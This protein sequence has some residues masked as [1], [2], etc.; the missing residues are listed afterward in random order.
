MSSGSQRINDS[1]VCSTQTINDSNI[2]LTQEYGP[3][4][5]SNIPYGLVNGDKIITKDAVESTMKAC[6]ERD[7]KMWQLQEHKLRLLETL[8]VD[9][10]SIEEHAAKIITSCLNKKKNGAALE[11]HELHL[12]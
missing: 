8:V 6:E 1:N 3:A 7:M 2:R 9:G 5:G 12:L 11:D 10:D 4:N